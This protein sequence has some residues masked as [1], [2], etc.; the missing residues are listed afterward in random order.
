MS[1]KVYPTLITGVP[2]TVWGYIPTFLNENNPK[3]TI[4]QFDAGYVAGWRK[5]DGFTLNK[6][7]LELSYPDDPPMLPRAVVKFKDD[8]IAI[9]DYSW[10]LVLMPSGEWE[11]CR[12]D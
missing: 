1:E 8:I 12:M 7:D 3:S 2:D 10:V 9:Y 4:E 6:N 11:V 5:F